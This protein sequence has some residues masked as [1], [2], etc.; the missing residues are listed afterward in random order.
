MELFHKNHTW[1]LVLLPAGRKVITY[2]WVFKKKE[3]MSSVEGVKFK[4]RV[5]ARGFHQRE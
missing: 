1:E 2:K 3:G 4:A 5:I